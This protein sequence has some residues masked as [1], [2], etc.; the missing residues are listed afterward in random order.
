MCIIRLLHFTYCCRLGDEWVKN[1]VSNLNLY[2]LDE[3]KFHSW[4]LRNPYWEAINPTNTCW[5]LFLCQ[6]LFLDARN[7]KHV[8]SAQISYPQMTYSRYR[9]TIYT[10][11]DTLIH[12]Y[13]SIQLHTD[14]YHLERCVCVNGLVHWIVGGFNNQTSTSIIDL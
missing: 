1:K 14:M 8:R 7:T 9:H 10:H 3:F 13:I 4:I 12:R 11:I 2:C 5:V 6:V